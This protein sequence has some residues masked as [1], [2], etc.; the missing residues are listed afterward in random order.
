MS[1]FN[2]L[3]IYREFKKEATSKL[4]F[5]TYVKFMDIFPYSCV[6]NVDILKLLKSYQ[7]FW[8]IQCRCFLRL[9]CGYLP[10][11]MCKKCGYFGKITNNFLIMV[12][13]FMWKVDILE[14]VS[15]KVIIDWEPKHHLFTNEYDCTSFN[16]PDFHKNNDLEIYI[17]FKRVTI[18]SLSFIGWGQVMKFWYTDQNFWNVF[19]SKKWYFSLTIRFTWK[20][21]WFQNITFSNVKFSFS[22][23]KPANLKYHVFDNFWNFLPIENMIFQ[24][25]H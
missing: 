11:F 7:F 8:Q 2:D 15:K 25:N 13:I 5:R 24:F 22:L 14:N 21:G 23:I 9:L 16:T 12:D 3:E 18:C 1:H 17:G 10:I 20:H 19:S 4:V 6:K